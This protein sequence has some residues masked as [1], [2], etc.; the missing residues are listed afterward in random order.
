M[1]DV[2]WSKQNE[3]KQKHITKTFSTMFA[4]Y[5]FLFTVMSEITSEIYGVLVMKLVCMALRLFFR[6]D[7]YLLR[8]LEYSSQ[9]WPLLKWKFLSHSLTIMI[10]LLVGDSLSYACDKWT[11]HLYDCSFNDAMYMK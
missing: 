7:R 11:F 5:L 6:F 3:T 10:Q 8:K 2:T 9:V 4:A 1:Q